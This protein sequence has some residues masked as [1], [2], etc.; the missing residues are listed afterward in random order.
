MPLRLLNKTKKNENLTNQ[1]ARDR[2]LEVKNSLRWKMALIFV[3]VNIIGLELAAPGLGLMSNITEQISKNSGLANELI[4]SFDKFVRYLEGG[5]ADFFVFAGKSSK[6]MIAGV[7][8][9]FLHYVFCNK[10]LFSNE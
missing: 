2:G 6:L 5:K 9:W 4:E 8:A 7:I 1:A 10:D 3:I